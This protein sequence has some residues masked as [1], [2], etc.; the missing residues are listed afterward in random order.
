LG[1]ELGNNLLF[2]SNGNRIF[3]GVATA[4]AVNYI[5]FSNKATGGSPTFGVVGTDTNIDLVIS[6]KGTGSMRPVSNNTYSNGT[7]SFYWSNI[8]GTRVNFNSTCYIDGGT[9]G[10]AIVNG[11]GSFA[12]LQVSA[13]QSV[14]FIPALNLLAPNITATQQVYF[15]I[16]KTGSTNNWASFGFNYA[17]SGSTSNSFSMNFYGT[18]NLLTITAAGKVTT[19]N[20]TLDDGSGNMTTAGNFTV[21]D[22]KNIV[23][24]TTTGTQIAT[25]GGASGQ[26]LAFWGSSPIVQPLLATGAAHTV[27]DVITVLQNLGLVRQS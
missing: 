16:G 20:N 10:Q 23:L 9:G 2:D 24:G 4:S 25:V 21:T 11:S 19:T 6:P 12:P 13:S 8:Y 17:G 15:A 18:G 5:Q 1:V 27:D 22:A 7:S 3:Q 14:G 26:K